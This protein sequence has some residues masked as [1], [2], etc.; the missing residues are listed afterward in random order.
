MGSWSVQELSI[1]RVYARSMLKLAEERG[2]GDSLLE[3]LKGLVENLDRDPAFGRFLASPLVDDEDRASFLERVF[4]GKASDLLVDSLQVVNRKGRLGLLRAI[5]EAYRMEHRDLRGMVDAYVRTV[6]PLTEPLRERVRAAV[7]RHTGKTP[8]LIEKID[9]SLI[10]GIVVQVGDTK[11][12][13]SLSRRLRELAA[14]L[15]NRATQEILRAR[16][17]GRTGL[18]P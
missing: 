9:P 14:N 2:E 17:E 10:A 8:V 4:R 11:I 5:A 18:Q 3:E 1:A 12:D 13:E 7:A 15:E 16:N 6:V